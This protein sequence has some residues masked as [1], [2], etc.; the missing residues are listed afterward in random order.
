MDIFLLIIGLLFCITGLIG[1]FIPIIPGPIT[2]WL[3]LL[4]LHFTS[5]VQLDYFFLLATFII[6]ITVFLLDLIIPLISLKKLGG[7]K[8]G[9][10]GASIGLLIGFFMGPIGI[11]TGPF[12]GSLSGE[13]IN[14]L[15]FKKAIKASFGTLIGLLAGFIMKFFVSFIFFAIYLKETLSIFF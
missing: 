9:I 15:G 14:N 7:T 12:I 6:A 5:I 10:I 3:G 4:I 13:L 1:S 8:K 11:L 2:S